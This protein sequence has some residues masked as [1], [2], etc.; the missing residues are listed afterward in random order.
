MKTFQFLLVFC[1]LFSV[2][3]TES[4][5]ENTSVRNATECLLDH[6]NCDF[7]VTDTVYIVSNGTVDLPFNDTEWQNARSCLLNHTDCDKVVSN[8]LH[9]LSNGTL[10]LPLNVADWTLNCLVN[11]TNC[12]KLA[13]NFLHYL[14]SGGLDLQLDD[15]F[16]SEAEA[17]FTGTE[18]RTKCSDEV[19]T[20]TVG[21]INDVISYIYG[22]SNVQ[23]KIESL[24]NCAESVE[25]EQ[26]DCLNI[27]GG[28][29]WVLTN[30][31]ID[32]EITG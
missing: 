30:G 28:V 22:N 32:V 29:L 2:Y 9:T 24:L 15:D 1:V 25:N 5:P 14:S 6:T 20:K 7:V 21:I 11:Q 4:Q 19:K 13:S 16:L 17:C 26:G 27:A 18:D 23:E 12:G 8:F 10:D 31:Y 3:G